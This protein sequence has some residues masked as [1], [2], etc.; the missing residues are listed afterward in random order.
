MDTF[1]QLVERQAEKFPNKAAVIFKE[2]RISYS[3]LNGR[4]NRLAHALLGMGI[5][6]GDKLALLMTNRPAMIEAVFACAKTGAVSVSL[7][8]RLAEPEI[9]Y[10]LEHSK[11]TTLIFGKEFSTVAANLKKAGTRIERWIC[12]DETNGEYEH[13]EAVLQGQPATNPGLSVVPE[14]DS[15][16]IYTSG[17]TGRPKGVLRTHRTNLW[18][19]MNTVVEMSYRTPDTELYT[20]PLFNVGMFNFVLP[21]LVTGCTLVA[22]EKFDVPA[23]LS[24][25]QKERVNR[26]FMVPTMWNM[27]INHPGIADFDLSSLEVIASGAESMPMELK[28]K[29]M[30]TF[31]GV[32]IWEVY[33]LSEGGKAFLRPEYAKTKNG[34]VGVGGFT[35]HVMVLDDLGNPVAPGEVGEVVVRSPGLLKE[36]FQNPEA[37]ASALKD[38]CLYTGDLGR[39]DEDGFLYIV[40]RKKDMIISG[41]ENI[42]PK[43]LEEVLYRHP[44]IFEASVI[45]VPDPNWGEKVLAAVRV[46]PGQSMTANEVIDFCQLHLASY[47]KPRVVKFMDELPRNPSGKVLKTELRKLFS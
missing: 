15:S 2:T 28:T 1:A 16:M 22:M 38:G 3:D 23:I 5:R 44:A 19:I 32:R 40:D 6:K 39:F 8:F 4:A 37:T 25:I 10:I 18:A 29:L 14:D 35:N 12:T 33:G 43:E 13:Y 17:T 42:Y 45:G 26:I 27:L 34:S 7:N 20:V 11:C 24:A 41:G 46:K 9:A 30:T 31:P 21:N 36:Y 47:K